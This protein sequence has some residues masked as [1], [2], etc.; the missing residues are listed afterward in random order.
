MG[1][2]I[3]LISVVLFVI[4]IALFQYRNDSFLK[5][6]HIQILIFIAIFCQALFLYYQNQTLKDHFRIQQRPV[7]VVSDIK[8]IVLSDGNLQTKIVDTDEF[9]VNITFKNIGQSPAFVDYVKVKVFYGYFLRDG[10]EVR[11]RL[12][13]LTGT[14][15]MPH[16]SLAEEVPFSSL[17]IFKD[18]IFSPNQQE[19][20]STMVDAKKLMDN[21]RRY[22]T[23]REAPI[24]IECEMKY[25]SSIDKTETYK[26]N[27]IYELQWPEAKHI[28]IYSLLN[29]SNSKNEPLHLTLAGL[30]QIVA[31]R[32]KVESVTK[33]LESGGEVLKKKLEEIFK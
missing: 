31:E 11:F 27:C 15:T 29:G 13:N 26:Y 10:D 6:E 18:S 25:S 7:V 3:V 5:N 2:I 16:K 14:Q 24:F 22:T 23:S 8:S 30:I 12:Q 20:Y 17:T 9:L 32:Q 1:I 28:N 4:G 33:A 21:I 19:S